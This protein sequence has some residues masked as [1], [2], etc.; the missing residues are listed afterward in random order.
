MYRFFVNSGQSPKSPINWWFYG[1]VPR[2]PSHKFQFTI[3]KL[4]EAEN[5]VEN[6]KRDTR[7]VFRN[8]NEFQF[9]LGDV[10][11]RG[12]EIAGIKIYVEE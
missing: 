7:E 10:V 6:S 9:S 5:V 2:I 8:N 3:I 12:S 1:T 11:V 4:T